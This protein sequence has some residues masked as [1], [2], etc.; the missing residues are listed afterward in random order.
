MKDD[1]KENLP[2]NTVKE[3]YDQILKDLSKAETLFNNDD[4][5]GIYASKEATQALLARVYL[6]MEDKA[7]AKEYADKLISSGKFT[8]LPSDKL[9]SYGES[10]PENNSE[11]IFAIKLV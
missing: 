8:L 1:P 5:N 3:V 10:V 4:R 11:T 6:Y 7:K 2:R 9:T